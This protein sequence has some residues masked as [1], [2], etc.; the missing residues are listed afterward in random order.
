MKL[1]LSIDNCFR[2]MIMHA[3]NNVSRLEFLNFEKGLAMKRRE[4]YTTEWRICLRGA[5]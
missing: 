5:G 3:R 2:R 4:G 1:R